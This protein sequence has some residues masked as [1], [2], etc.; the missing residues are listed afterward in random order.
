MGEAC[1]KLTECLALLEQ[2]DAGT[3][4]RDRVIL[5]NNRSGM[6]ERMAQY[7]AAL[8]DIEAVLKLMPDHHKC[9]V[10]RARIFEKQG[11]MKEA[12]LEYAIAMVIESNKGVQ[13]MLIDG[14]KTVREKVE[15]I[16]KSVAVGDAM[17]LFETSQENTSRAL[18]GKMSCND[19]FDVSPT[20]HLYRKKA[21]IADRRLLNSKVME[22]EEQAEKSAEW[23]RH[24]LDLI[25]HD[26]C[27]GAFKNAFALVNKALP[28]ARVL[29]ESSQS[30]MGE[31]AG[32]DGASVDAATAL[33]DDVLE[34]LNLAGAEM[35]LRC[36]QGRA[37]A[38]F[39][40]VLVISP[41]N[42]EA[43][44]RLA[45]CLTESGAI[46]RAE[47][48]YETLSELYVEH[49]H[50]EKSGDAGATRQLLNKAFSA[51]QI[52]QDEYT[53]ERRMELL[54]AWVLTHRIILQKFRAED[55]QWR[56]GAI[57]NAMGTISEILTTTGTVTHDHS[58][59]SF[60][61]CVPACSHF[62]R[63]ALGCVVLLRGTW[64]CAVRYTRLLN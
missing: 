45:D 31:G 37:I 59:L 57:S 20:Y 61:A 47:K 41:D 27:H 21:A 5:L 16:N 14:K 53:L 25:W 12:L 42:L 36:C 49:V 52:A 54:K 18:Q 2:L 8:K 24:I 9:R 44:L 43:N 55:G 26:I 22:L 64:R 34:L 56:E 28:D 4:Q 58:T 15:D 48:L 60:H 33:R 1:E 30:A 32:G 46:S 23:L 39:E 7:D 13:S 50:G 35:T 3:M 11:K 38:L 29:L 51:H 40:E 62:S 19:F 10:R 6:Y 17:E 63:T